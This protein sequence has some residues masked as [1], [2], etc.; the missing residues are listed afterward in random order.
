MDSLATAL[1]VKTED[2]PRDSPYLVPGRPTVGI[3]PLLSDA[4]LVTLATVRAM[5]GLTS[6]AERRSWWSVA[7]GTG[8]RD[9]E[10]DE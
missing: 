8:G 4:E 3:T 10:G 7:L 6:E 5:L 2:L 1:H 9:A